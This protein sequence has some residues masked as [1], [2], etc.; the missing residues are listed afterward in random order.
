MSTV[1]EIVNYVNR[2]YPN[3][4][5]DAN[6]VADLDMIHKDVYLR[7][8]RLSN[9]FVIYEDITI[10]G[11]TFY[12][13]PSSIRIED[14]VRIDVET[15]VNSDN[16]DTFEYAGVKDEVSGRQVY[17]RGESG[18]Y[19]LM[20]DEEPIAAGG[21]NIM[22]YYYPRPSDLSS[23]NM[24]AIPALDVDYHSILKYLLIVELANQGHNPDTEIADYWQKK[25]DEKMR[26][27]ESA[28]A[29]RIASAR[30]KTECDE[31]W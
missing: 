11:Q 28:L 9:D 12:N 6:K 31:I 30:T 19:A 7:I 13:L 21:K 23:S 27:I 18:T 5:T 2:K 22:L 17:M 25:A 3:Q 16:Y 26:E 20:D 29:E 14:V 4:E 1:Q 24:T 15:G 8:R 10:A